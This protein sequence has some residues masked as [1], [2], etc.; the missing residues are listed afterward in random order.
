MI[1][2]RLSILSMEIKVRKDFVTHQRCKPH[3]RKRASMPHINYQSL[4]F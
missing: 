4:L 1:E 3:L 2:T